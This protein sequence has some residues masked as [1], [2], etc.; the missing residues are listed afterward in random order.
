MI[1]LLKAAHLSEIMKLLLC[2]LMGC[3]GATWLAG[4]SS[5][6][7]SRWQLNIQLAL[8]ANTRAAVAALLLAGSNAAMP[9]LP[10]FAQDSITFTEF[11]KK[12]NEG[13]YDRVV[14][15][16]IRPTYLEAFEKGGAAFVVQD[17][18]PAFDDPLSP[19]GPA[20]AIALCQHTPGV[21]C[22]QD[23]SDV[24]QLSK[25]K[26]QLGEGGKKI[27]PML[28][29]SSYMNEYAYDGAK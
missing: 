19:S 9:A 25:T 10:A 26:K 18:F 14:F 15:V 27:L 3:I 6:L 1:G 2:I 4:V 22:M 17:G 11:K 5:L 8:N 23:I 13:V 28:S 24:M 7:L 29:H 16:G 20:Q 21:V 12:L